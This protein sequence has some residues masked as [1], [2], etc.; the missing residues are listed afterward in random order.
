MAAI[1]PLILFTYPFYKF[2]KT[3]PKA[4]ATSGITLKFLLDKFWEQDPCIGLDF[5]L[6]SLSL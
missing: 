5:L 1:F 3:V 2:L 6:L 4:P